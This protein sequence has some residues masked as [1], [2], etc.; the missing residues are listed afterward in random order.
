MGYLQDVDGIAQDVIS[1][2]PDPDDDGRQEYIWESVDGSS[3]ITYY[4][5]IEEVLRVSSNEPDGAEVTDMAGPDAD[6]RKMQAVAAFMA[7]EADVWERVRELDD[8]AE[9]DAA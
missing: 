1:E 6:W 3:N 8:E 2:Y 4:S 9:S 5:E 7:M